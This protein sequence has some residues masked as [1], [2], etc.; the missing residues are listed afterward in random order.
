[1]FSSEYLYRP[2]FGAH[3]EMS[4]HPTKNLAPRGAARQE[5]GQERTGQA[6]RQERGQREEQGAHSQGKHRNAYL[7][8]HII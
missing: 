7:K 2:I 1:M 6:A 8:Y 3:S 5:R 4:N